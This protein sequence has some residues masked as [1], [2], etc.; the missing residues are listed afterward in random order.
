M[1]TTSNWN[2]LLKNIPEEKFFTKFLIYSVMRHFHKK[3]SSNDPN[4]D[5]NYILVDLLEHLQ[6]KWDFFYCNLIMIDPL[7][8]AIFLKYQTM[9]LENQ[10]NP[11]PS[12]WLCICE[13]G[14]ICC[15]GYFKYI[16]KVYKI[17]IDQTLELEIQGK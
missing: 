14:T 8:M 10:V 4:F 16:I 1:S 7:L 13:N 2:D 11:V 9:G 6:P 17:S 15:D 12:S 5:V 3:P